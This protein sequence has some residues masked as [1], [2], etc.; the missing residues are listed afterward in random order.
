M[1]AT[2]QFTAETETDNSINY[3]DI[4][5]HRSPTGLRTSIFRK[6]TFT[7]T[8]IPYTSKHPTQHKYTAIKFL[9]H[10]LNTY[11]LQ[12]QGHDRELNIIHNILYNNAFP[13]K[14]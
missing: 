13:I 1:H 12:K 2:L 9:Y 4:S 5:I 14:N 3:L 11:N 10:R 8:I 6:P 7:D